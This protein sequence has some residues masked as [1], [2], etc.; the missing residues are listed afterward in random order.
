M[1]AQSYSNCSFST[2]IR[3]VH[4]FRGKRG[5]SFVFLCVCM[6]LTINQPLCRTLAE[7]RQRRDTQNHTKFRNNFE[8]IASSLCGR[9]SISISVCHVHTQFSP[10]RWLCDALL[11]ANTLAQYCATRSCVGSLFGRSVGFVRC[12]PVFS[13]VRTIASFFQCL[14]CCTQIARECIS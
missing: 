8:C 14:L 2:V 7:R 5:G 1:R 11:R 13:D 4:T 3:R 6:W 10:R 9:S 12:A